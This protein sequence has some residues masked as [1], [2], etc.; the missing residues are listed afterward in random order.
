[1]ER[2]V[3]RETGELGQ[4]LHVLVR[5]LVKVSW[6]RDMYICCVQQEVICGNRVKIVVIP[7]TILYTPCSTNPAIFAKYLRVM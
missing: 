2:T 4:K 6:R 1:M 3:Y 7:P 5:G